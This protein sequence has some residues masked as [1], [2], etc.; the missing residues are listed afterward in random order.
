VRHGPIW[1]G[2][3]YSCLSPKL[4]GGGGGHGFRS[5]SGEATACRSLGVDKW[6]R[7]N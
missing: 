1:M 5:D 2:L 3:S 7:G 4:G 6:H